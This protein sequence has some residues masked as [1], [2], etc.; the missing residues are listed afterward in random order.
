M[1]RPNKEDVLTGRMYR[2]ALER[3]CDELEK[4]LDKA[5]E[6]LAKIDTCPD[7]EEPEECCLGETNE[8]AECWKEWVLKDE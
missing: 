8:C 2:E 5:C 4:A 7:R 1:N 6:E 3:Y